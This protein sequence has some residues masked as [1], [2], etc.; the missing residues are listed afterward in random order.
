M[1]APATPLRLS[2]DVLTKL[3]AYDAQAA[4]GLCMVSVRT[5][6]RA[7]VHDRVYTSPKGGFVRALLVVP[8][9][10]GPFA[11]LIIQHG[12]AEDE[13]G[14]S[15]GREL[16]LPYAC[17]LAPTGAV[18][19]LIDAPFARGV[20]THRPEGSFT[21]TA[22][23][24][25]EQ[26]QLIVDLRRAVDLLSAR[27]EI[28][29][30]RL[31]YI[32]WSYGAAIGGLL[33]AIE[34]RIKAYVLAVGGGGVVAH[35]TGTGAGSAAFRCLSARQQQDW[36]VVMAPIEPLHYVGQAHP[37]ALLF[38]AALHDQAVPIAEATAFH[39]AGSEPKRIIT[40]N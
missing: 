15:L 28:D 34:R 19:L 32:G 13:T 16:L 24:H 40:R 23:D 33:A 18:C 38:Q 14:V 29:E 3:F 39:Q 9:G 12:V 31:G 35:F 11:G 6:A 21:F 1:T 22:Q 2:D 5:A 36:Q 17:Y 25:D 37:A 8:D 20:H 4:L 30:Q 26:V 10:S 27:P 7:T